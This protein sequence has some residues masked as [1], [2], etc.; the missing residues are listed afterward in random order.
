MR[1]LSTAALAATVGATL[2]APA[3]AEINPAAAQA[4]QP[5]SES[6]KLTLENAQPLPVPPRPDVGARKAPPAPARFKAPTVLTAPELPQIQVGAT[7]APPPPPAGAP[8]VQSA[9]KSPAPNAAPAPTPGQSAPPPQT[10][11]QTAAL[12]P[13]AQ[14]PSQAPRPAAKTA[15]LSLTFDPTASSLPDSAEAPLSGIA[16]RMRGNPTL[17]LQLRAYAEGTPD[18]VREARQLSLA[19]ALAV[20]ERLGAAGVASTRVDIRALGIDAAG[21]TPDR[22]D[23]EFLNE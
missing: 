8:P 12:P 6:A 4:A 22:V 21:G 20:R 18:T 23:I 3:D 11:T 13:A 19:R 16:E 5:P 15:P 7:P 9:A 1:V 14:P 17:R 2:S 10:R